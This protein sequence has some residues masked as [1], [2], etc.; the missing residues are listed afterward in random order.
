MASTLIDGT[1]VVFRAGERPVASVSRAAAH[2]QSIS[3]HQL[4]EAALMDRVDTKFLLPT[5]QLPGVLEH[6]T[7]RYRVL[8][9]NGRRLSRYNTRYF[10]TSD[11]KLYHDHHSGRAHR[12]KVRVRS[13]VDSESRFLEVK[14]KTNKARTLKARMSLAHDAL[15]PMERLEAERFL[16]FESG[17]SP[18]DLTE[19]VVVDYSR[20]TLVRNDAPERITLDLMLT[21]TRRDRIHSY[22]GVAIAE[23]KQARR[24]DSPFAEAMRE[25]RIRQGGL[26]KYC[27]GVATLEP[28]VKKNRFKE[29]IRRLEKTG[30][31]PHGPV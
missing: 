9:V 16:G 3:L 5:W 4:G 20:L 10:D 21:F 31:A 30:A 17:V 19:A 28:S 22:P 15:S 8:E 7:G 6:L 2:F 29:G 27:L 23:L 14:L 1:P 26:S 18:A 13:Y 12:H 25:L 11:L 24:G